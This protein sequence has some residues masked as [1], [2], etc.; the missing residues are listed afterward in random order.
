MSYNHDRAQRLM[1]E[2]EMCADQKLSAQWAIA[3]G[4][5]AIAASI[6]DSARH[7][8]LGNA[9]S[10]MGAIEALCVSVNGVADAIQAVA[11]REP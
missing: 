9:F 6:E 11:D 1:T 4:L 10:P 7:L 3:G 5:F 8:G 2:C